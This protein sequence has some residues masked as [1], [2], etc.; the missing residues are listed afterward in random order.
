MTRVIV[1]GGRDVDA[2]P[3][4]PEVM[5]QYFDPKN[6]ILVNGGCPTGVDAIALHYAVNRHAVH[7]VFH[8]DWDTHGKAA[9]PIRNREMAANADVLIAF[10]DGKSRGTKSMI[11]E[12]LRHQLEVHVY[13]YEAA[14]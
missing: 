9:G 12:A 4:L 3:Q 14:E 2:L 7:Q 1:A 11:D 10:W 5:E 6:D 13:F 8:A